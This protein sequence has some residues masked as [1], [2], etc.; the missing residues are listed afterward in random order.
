MAGTLSQAKEMFQ[1]IDSENTGVISRD[2]LRMLMQEI[3]GD[4]WA[5]ENFD[6]MLEACGVAPGCADVEYKG[7]LEQLLGDEQDKKTE[8]PK[9]EAPNGE[10]ASEETKSAPGA[11]A[12]SV[13]PS[14]QD[15][16][17]AEALVALVCARIVASIKAAEAQPEDSAGDAPKVDMSAGDPAKVDASKEESKPE[18]VKCESKLE[19]EAP[20]AA[21]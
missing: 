15:V 7:F 12:A 3:G 10:E 18:E 4:S 16:A 17:D 20:A 1:S 6:T 2:E 13:S 19:V 11:E 21:A 9:D 14:A 8:A 5:G